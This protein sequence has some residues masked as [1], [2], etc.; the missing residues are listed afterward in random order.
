MFLSTRSPVLGEHNASDD[1]KFCSIN[2]SLLPPDTNRNENK[3]RERDPYKSFLGFKDNTF[4]LKREEFNKNF[5][6]ESTTHPL[7]P[8]LYGTV[9]LLDMAEDDRDECLLVKL[10]HDCSISHQSLWKHINELSA[11][12]HDHRGTNPILHVK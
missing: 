6:L 10:P 7:F 4:K 3:V 11:Y 9:E 2:A 5:T 1:D 12:P 8:F